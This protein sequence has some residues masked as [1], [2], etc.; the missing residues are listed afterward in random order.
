MRLK[1]SGAKFSMCIQ[2]HREQRLHL[3]FETT[4]ELLIIIVANKY[5]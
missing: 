5:K 1:G 4:W 3:D 2:R